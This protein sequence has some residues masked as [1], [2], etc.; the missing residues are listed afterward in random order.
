LKAIEADPSPP[1]K[2]QIF[3]WGNENIPLGGVIYG[4]IVYDET[5][6]IIEDPKLRSQ[7]WPG[8][9]RLNI[10]DDRWIT[11]EIPR[12]KRSVVPYDEHFYY[13]SL[14]CT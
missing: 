9:A 8:H 14:V 5:D 10:P 13:V 3:H 12:C 6:K 11:A 4:A 7:D 2:Y 1:P